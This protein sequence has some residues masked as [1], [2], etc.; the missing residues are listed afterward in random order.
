MIDFY[1]LWKK[2]PLA[3]SQRPR[4]RQRR[5]PTTILRRIKTANAALNSSSAAAKSSRPASS[6]F[7]DFSSASENEMDE[8]DSETRDLS[9]YACHHCYHTGKII[10]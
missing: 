7:L 5:P 9:G 10:G 6:E 3:N 1:Y 8:S 4:Q 2:S